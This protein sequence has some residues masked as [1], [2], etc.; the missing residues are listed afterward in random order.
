MK[1]LELFIAAFIEGFFI[2]GAGLSIIGIRPKLAT[3]A[4]MGATCALSIYGV[5]IVYETFP[6]PL[7]THSFVLIALY[8]VIIKYIGKQ[9]WAAA[10]VTPL[11][12]FLLINIGEGMILFNVIKLLGLSVNDILSRPGFRVLGAILTDIPLIIVFVTGYILKISVIDINRFV[13]KEDI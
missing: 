12:S 9:N 11:I 10:I 13:E 4:Y 3:I 5:R 6:V 8:V 2:V 7:G 1:T